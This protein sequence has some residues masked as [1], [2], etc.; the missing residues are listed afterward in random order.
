MTL[1]A[2]ACC[3]C[4]EILLECFGQEQ[5]IILFQNKGHAA[6]AALAVDA[7]DR[8]VVSANIHRVDGQIRNFPSVRMG[9]HCFHA[10]SDGVLMGTGESGIYQRTSIGV[11]GRNRHSCGCFIN[12]HSLVDLCKVQFGINPLR[13]DIH[14]Y[15]HDVCIACSFTVAEQ[16]AFYTIS[17][18][19]QRQFSGG[20]SSASVIVGVQADMDTVSVFQVFAAVFDLVCV[21][22]GCCHFYCGRQIDDGFMVRCGFPHIQNRIADFN[23]K[24]HFCTGKAFGR[25]FK[26][27]FCFGHFCCFFQDQFCTSHCQIDSFLHGVAENNISLQSRC[28]IIQMYDGFFGTLQGF[29]GFLDDVRSALGQHLYDDIIGDHIMFDQISGKFKFCVAGCREPNFDFLKPRFYQKLKK[30][31]FFFQ[32]HGNFQGLIAV[33][34]IYTAPDR[35]FFDRV[36]WPFSVWHIHGWIWSVLLVVHHLCFLLQ[37]SSFVFFC[38]FLLYK[39]KKAHHLLNKRRKAITFRGTTLVYPQ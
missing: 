33:T 4:T 27:E 31:Q 17:P 3:N 21:N 30:S 22:V 38:V 13:E 8:V 29:K 35:C 19:H 12:P 9:F 23:G 28:G 26:K 16:C 1:V 15:I 14:S 36:I 10:F 32:I 24:G 39:V 18:C 6:F 25:I 11:S 5:T 37:I 20:N 7:D 2:H 34:H